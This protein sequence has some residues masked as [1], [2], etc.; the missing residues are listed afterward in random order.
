MLK[1]LRGALALTL[2][3]SLSLSA[4]ATDLVIETW[5]IDDAEL[6]RTQI[7][8]AFQKSHPEISVTLAAV[9]AAEYETVLLER[10]KAGKAGDLI[11]CRPYDASLKLF[12]DGYLTDL[13]EFP[14]LEN[15]PR[16]ARSAWQTDSG[17]QTFCLPIA[18]VIQGFYYNKTI[19]KE[20]G[21]AVPK[22]RA[23]FFAA[24]DKVRQDGRYQPLVM[25]VH[26]NW[27]T[28]ELGYQNIGPN[29]WHGEDGRTALLS[30][31]QK[32]TDAPYVAVFDELAR[33]RP[34]LGAAPEQLDEGQ[35]VALFAS[36]K[37]AVI[38]AG[39]WAIS[40]FMGKVDFDAFPPPVAEEGD[41]CYFTDHT[42][43]GIGINAASPN[44]AAALTLLE[45]MSSAEFAELFSNS[46]PGFFSLSNHFFEL[47]NPVASTMAS[48]RD[49]CDSTIRVATQIL[50][51]GTPSLSSELNEVTQ[52]VMLGQLSPAEAAARLEQGL[53]GWYGPQQQA[54]EASLLDNCAPP[55]VSPAA[56]SADGTL[57]AAAS[58]AAAVDG[59]PASPPPT[60]Q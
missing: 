29:Y 8:P 42:D 13:T 1:L 30:G 17:A 15:F 5:R 52:A 10:L 59:T 34:Y 11:T 51:R 33:W 23:Q 50:S 27:I 47:D 58:G 25:P 20:L 31:K 9:H 37:A 3:W 36:G 57:D 38:V 4:L 26:D 19:F 60:G 39:S 44:Q 28:S 16:F 54:A 24:L 14:G 40:Q 41:S 2:G 55:T 48:W 46:V 22:T 35:A 21:L 43:I 56:S 32:F 49:S 6:W 18:S 53:V 12:Q 45:W 7:L